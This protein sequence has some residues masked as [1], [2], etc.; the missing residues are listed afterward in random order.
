[1]LKPCP[2]CGSDKIRLIGF[3]RFMCEGCSVQIYLPDEKIN[4]SEE[5]EPFESD[6]A[7]A[8]KFWNT[9]P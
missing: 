4:I 7:N 9:R 3:W 1:M 5:D 8:V 6:R 2:F